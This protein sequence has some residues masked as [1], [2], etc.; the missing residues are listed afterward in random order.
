MTAQLSPMASTLV[1]ILGRRKALALMSS[2]TA[3]NKGT[4]YV[5]ASPKPTSKLARII[6]LAAAESLAQLYGGRNV[7]VPKCA[8]LQLSARHAEIIRMVAEGIPQVEVARR[9]GMTD[10]NVRHVLASH[11]AAHSR[12]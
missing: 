4:I 2:V 5:P 12:L 8:A 9:F 1:A 11:R 7:T 10:R 3:C 6:G